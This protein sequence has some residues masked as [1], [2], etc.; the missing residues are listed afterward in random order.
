MW[1]LC[2][3]C[4]LRI[5]LFHLARNRNTNMISSNDV[6]IGTNDIGVGQCVSFLVFWRSKPSLFAPKTIVQKG[7]QN[8]CTSDL[9]T[10]LN[11]F[12]WECAVILCCSAPYIGS[13]NH[14]YT[15]EKM[16]LSL[17]LQDY[18]D[19]RNIVSFHPKGRVCVLFCSEMCLRTF[20][21][22]KIC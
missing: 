13:F 16:W 21:R 18:L 10:I 1:P 15:D 2:S 19:S 4:K 22:T 17:H 8:R 12:R 6:R 20:P 14:T 5:V 7:A 11:D 9:S 3:K